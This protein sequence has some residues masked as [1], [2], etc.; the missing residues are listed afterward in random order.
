MIIYQRIMNR[1]VTMRLNRFFFPP[2]YQ[3]P[4]YHQPNQYPPQ[5]SQMTQPYFP[6]A[7]PNMPFHQGNWQPPFQ[8]MQGMGVGQKPTAKGVMGYFQ[9]EQG[10]FDLDKVLNT[11]GQVANTYQQIS[12]LVKGIGS[13]LKG[14]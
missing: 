3:M 10:Q 11:A 13:F 14:S 8:G 9:N 12:P 4:N 6:P 1:G 2:N 7:H 5:Y